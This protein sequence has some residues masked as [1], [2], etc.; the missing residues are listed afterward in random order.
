[1][2]ICEYT[3]L[4]ATNQN[5]WLERLPDAT[6]TRCKVANACDGEQLFG[7]G[8]ML[9]KTYII[10]IIRVSI[11]DSTGVDEQVQT[12]TLYFLSSG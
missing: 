10:I 9:C 5:I 11:N 2:S 1:M 12:L 3:H 4:D 8:A 7:W 6:H